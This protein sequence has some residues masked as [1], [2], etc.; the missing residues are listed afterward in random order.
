MSFSTRRALL[1][2]IGSLILVQPAL[3]QDKWS[4]WSNGIQLR[5]DNIFQRRVYS[6]DTGNFLGPGP[7]GPPYAQSDLDR[8]RAEGANV[9]QISGPGLYTENPPYVLDTGV[10]TNL[11]N[12]ITMATNAGLHVVISFRTGPGRSEAAFNYFPPGYDNDAVWTNQAAHDA[13]VAM[14]TY[15]ANRYKNN[16]QVVG[17]DLMVEPNSNHRLFDD[18]DPA[19]FYAAHG[20]TLADWNPLAAAITTGIRSVDADTPIIVCG[21]SYGSIFWL[22]YIVP[23]GDTKTVYSTH[24]YEPFNY[25]NQDFPPFGVPIPYPGHFD[26]DGGGAVDVNKAWLENELS[27]IDTWQNAH[28]TLPV[29]V[30]EFGVV[31]Y[32]PGAETYMADVTSIFEAKGVTHFQWM[33]KSTWAPSLSDDMFDITHGPDPAN[34]ADVP[35]NAL[36]QAVRV[37]WSPIFRNNFEGGTLGAWASSV[38]DGGDLSLTTVSPITGT[39]SL[40]AVVNDLNPLYV[41]DDRP[42]D[43]IHYR[44]RFRFNTGDYDPGTSTGHFRTRI[45]LGFEEA[46]DRRLFAV[47]LKYQSGQYSLIGRAR[48]DDN[49]QADIPPFAIA[50][51]TH[52]V[53]IEW[54]RA[55]GP[56]AGDGFF[57][58]FVDGALIGEVDGLQS[59]VSR[60]DYVRL[61]VMNIKDGA[62]GTLFFDDFD[63]QRTQYI[64]F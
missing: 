46:P 57:G 24:Y 7:V 48:Q 20:N 13:W 39:Y 51:G 37:D 43:E 10:Q 59:Y 55:S 41:V 64:G 12:L 21:M 17:Y 50:P 61:G 18:F 19:H 44:A 27:P 40:Q 26:P 2:F 38:T 33:W 28:P 5:G 32:A 35:D 56:A 53:E 58:L 4:L 14:W 45:F 49:S 62:S 6:F 9:A 25:T 63:S 31:R 36:L 54:I 60:L 23:T 11:D 22:N 1:V 42:L 15:T 52:L 34:H 8:L 3:A 29:I 47:V 30:G 16:P